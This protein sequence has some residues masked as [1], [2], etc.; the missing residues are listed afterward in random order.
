LGPIGPSQT[1]KVPNAKLY[2]LTYSFRL[3]IDVRTAVE[4]VK[5]ISFKNKKSSKQGSTNLLAYIVKFCIEG[6]W[7]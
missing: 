7:R 3:K 5:I 4:K 1:P 6:D 2:Y